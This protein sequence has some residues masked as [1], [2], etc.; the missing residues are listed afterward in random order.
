MMESSCCPLVRVLMAAG[1]MSKPSETVSIA[2]R[3]IVSLSNVNS[4][5]D[6][7]SV[8]FQFLTLK[9]APTKGNE[10]SEEKVENPLV[11]KPFLPSEHATLFSEVV[12]LP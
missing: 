1:E 3:K 11:I 4:Q 2:V 12:G 5:H 9:A 10:G 8:E 7:H 6:P